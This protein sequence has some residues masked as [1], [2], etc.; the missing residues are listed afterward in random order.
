MAQLGFSDLV[1]RFYPYADGHHP[2]CICNSSIGILEFQN[3][4][5]SI[6]LSCFSGIFLSSS[7]RLLTICD[8]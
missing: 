7:R 2:Y 3:E 8:Y 6:Y 5:L 1:V 4:L